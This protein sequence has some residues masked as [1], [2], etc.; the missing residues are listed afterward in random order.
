MRVLGVSGSPLK[1]SNTDRALKIALAAT[2][3][4]T[5]FIKLSDY[6]LQPCN[7]CL[8][9]RKTNS[10]VLDDDGN[11]LM[12]KA[13]KADALIIA[14]FTPYSSIDSRTKIFME[15]LYPLH[16]QHG[17]MGG[18]PGAAIVTCAIPPGHQGM[19]SASENGLT[20]IR[21]YMIEESMNYIGGVTVMGNVPCVRCGENGQ[22][23]V[24]SLKMLYGSNAT[25]ESVGMNTVEDDRTTVT[26]LEKLGADIVDAY[27]R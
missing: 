18:K 13:F 2:G 3:A 23:G 17:L 27:Y 6:H 4:R 10:C 1:N 16:H 21:N 11:L 8:D 14:G 20:A 25:P 12:N 22:C 9:C 5:E 19:P 26:A 7:A 15:R 24:S